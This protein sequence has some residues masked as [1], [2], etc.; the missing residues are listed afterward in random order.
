MEIC[1]TADQD[2]EPSQRTPSHRV[3]RENTDLLYNHLQI[4]SLRAVISLCPLCLGDLG[5]SWSF[6]RA[7]KNCAACEDFTPLQRG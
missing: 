3:H 7:W 6:T 1:L 5:G 4:N 2:Q